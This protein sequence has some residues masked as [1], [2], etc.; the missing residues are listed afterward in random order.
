[1]IKYISLAIIIT[2]FISQDCYGQRKLNRKKKEDKVYYNVEDYSL[3]QKRIDSLNT[4]IVDFISTDINADTVLLNTIQS[5]GFITTDTTTYEI[6]FFECNFITKCSD[7]L[8]L[9][10]H[11]EWANI[12]FLEFLIENIRAECSKM[13]AVSV[14]INFDYG[15]T[16]KLESQYD[17]IFV[18]KG[19]AIKERN[20]EF[21]KISN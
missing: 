6:V 7:T 21:I 12:R 9:S 19:F 10:T 14:V 2:F 17:I 1:M 13:E 18:D 4:L 5:S 15:K 16:H 20:I 11:D 8:K 3:A